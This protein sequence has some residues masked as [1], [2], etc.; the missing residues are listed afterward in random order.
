MDLNCI[1]C[2]PA[3]R[4]RIQ[5]LVSPPPK[6]KTS[7]CNLKVGNRYN[8]LQ[9]KEPCSEALDETCCCRNI[10]SGNEVYAAYLSLS[11]CCVL[12][13]YQDVLSCGANLPFTFESCTVSF[14]DPK[15]Y[16]YIFL[17]IHSQRISARLCS[18]FIINGISLG[19]GLKAFK[20]LVL[21]NLIWAYLLLYAV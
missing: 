11:A 17:N 6:V 4:C 21:P 13:V 7:V 10:S 5:W 20:L 8:N 18:V 2:K 15:N 12:K 19:F 1:D 16:I 9:R 3:C 14:L